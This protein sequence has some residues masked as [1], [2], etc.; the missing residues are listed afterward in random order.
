ML[1]VRTLL[2]M[3]TLSAAG[4]GTAS[5]QVFFRMDYSAGGGA[6]A[7]WPGVVNVQPT[8][9]RTRIAGGGPAGEDVYELAQRST[10]TSMPDYGS[11][12]YWGWAGEIEPSNPPQGARRYYRWRLWFSPN[13]NFR[14]INYSGERVTITNKLL[15]LG[16]SCGDRCRVIFTYRGQDNGQVGHLRLQ[17]DGGEDLTET[18]PINTGRW[19]DVQI[20]VDSSSSPSTADGGYKMWINNNDYARP[21]AVRSNIRLNPTGWRYVRL[22]A[23]NNDG[24][25]SDG[26]HTLRIGGFEASTAFDTGWSRGAPGSTTP[27][28]PNNLRI[29]P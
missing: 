10:G 13:S 2:L 17:I 14:G 1:K 23:Y 18:G 3:L 5:A 19:L 4:A 12:F 27:S 22:G 7:G 8:H 15:I 9:T 25:A 21:T 29:V 26:V 28:A 16:D 20:E 6:A 11:N 24:L